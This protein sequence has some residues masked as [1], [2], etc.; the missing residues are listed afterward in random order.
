MNDA[1]VDMARRHGTNVVS[2]CVIQAE[3]S[4]L[5]ISVLDD[6]GR[7][8][9]VAFLFSNA[10]TPVIVDIFIVCFKEAIGFKIK[11]RILVTDVGDSFSFAWSKHM[12]EPHSRLYCGYCVELSWKEYSES[13]EN[14]EK[15]VDVKAALNLMKI[16]PSK[17]TF[18]DKIKNALSDWN[19]SPDTKQFASYFVLYYSRWPSRWAQSCN[20]SLAVV[21]PPFL[22]LHETISRIYSNAYAKGLDSSVKA[23]MKH[24]RKVLLEG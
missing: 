14:Q 23:L 19:S 1:Q 5:M 21:Q 6:L 9:P 10:I 13:I 20:E 16:E 2:A 15:R 17:A 4:T 18:S 24:V 11:P 12:I 7:G 8:V 3:I 22:S